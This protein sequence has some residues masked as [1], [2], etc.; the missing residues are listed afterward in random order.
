MEDCSI[1]RAAQLYWCLLCFNYFTTRKRLKPNET[2]QVNCQ[3]DGDLK[4]ETQVGRGLREVRGDAEAPQ[5]TWAEDLWD[6]PI[7]AALRNWP[8][9]SLSHLG[10]FLPLLLLP[11]SLLVHCAVSLSLA[12]SVTCGFHFPV[13]SAYW[14]L[15]FGSSVSQDPGSPTSYLSTSPRTISNWVG[16]TK[17]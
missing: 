5:K 11:T 8:D 2:R 16:P 17:S 4:T 12:V 15:L 9:Y 6:L 3:G 1:C 13:T 10:V 7:S 14:E